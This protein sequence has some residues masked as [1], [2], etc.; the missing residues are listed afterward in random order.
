MA[1]VL[2]L[3][4]GV[5][6]CAVAHELTQRGA[7]V[8]LM[9]PRGI[10]LGASQASAGMLAPYTE[11]RHDPIM[12]TLGVQ[13]LAMY[14]GLVEALRSEG[15]V[16]GYTRHGSM[17]VALDGADA[18]RLADDAA[19]LA[20]EGIAHRLL[21]GD[22]ARRAMPGI[23]TS[24]AA[25][26]EVGAHGC[27]NVSDLVRSLWQAAERRHAR[28]VHGGATRLSPGHG[29]V[30]VEKGHRRPRR[31]GGP[32]ATWCRGTTARCWWARP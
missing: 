20:R 25:A 5:I 27:V 16:V 6:G 12:Q 1:D 10:G 21:D 32:A 9:D 7:D 23:A 4:G 18:V 26:L 19:A 2:I 15:E 31:S 11:G 14:D 8:V 29:T 24:V 13:S 22:D 3:G 28:L 17:E 30:R